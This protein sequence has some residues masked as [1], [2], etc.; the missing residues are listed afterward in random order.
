MDASKLFLEQVIFQ[1]RFKKGFLYWDRTGRIWRR[2]SETWDLSEIKVDTQNALFMI[3]GDKI[4]LGFDPDNI[5]TTQSVPESDLKNYSKFTHNAV[6]IVTEELEIEEFTRVGNRFK[7]LYPLEKAS[8]VSEICEKSGI[9]KIFP[10]KL[11]FSDEKSAV[12]LLGSQFRISEE[13]GMNYGVRLGYMDRK[14]EFDLPKL[15]TVKE[16][17]IIR[18]ALVIDI[19]RYTDKL[20]DKKTLDCQKLIEQNR[21]FI[22]NKVVGM[23]SEALK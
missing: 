9:I 1:V 15:V 6:S 19:D 3:K 17:K 14:V 2:L 21:E 7:F 23:F 18:K 13:S 16:D 20:C 8:D 11:K 4:Q 22:Y 12:T 10:E 5:N